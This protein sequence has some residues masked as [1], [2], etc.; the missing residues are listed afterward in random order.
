[1]SWKILVRGSFHLTP[2]PNQ[3]PNIG[4][5]VRLWFLVL[6]PACLFLCCETKMECWLLW[7]VPASI[8]VWKS[9]SGF[10]PTWRQ[11]PC[12]ISPLLSLPCFL[13]IDRFHSLLQAKSRCWVS[14]LISVQAWRSPSVLRTTE[15]SL[16]MNSS[17]FLRWLWSR[18]LL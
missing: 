13:S 16:E 11:P 18:D 3:P 1:M 17:I 9:L 12:K 7:P 2:L 8:S 15:Q 5:P 10:C 14:W 4:H 6:V